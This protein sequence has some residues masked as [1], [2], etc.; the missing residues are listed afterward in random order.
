MADPLGLPLLSETPSPDLPRPDLAVAVSIQG[1][2]PTTVLP[3]RDGQEFHP[4]LGD[5]LL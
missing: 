1:S 4:M 5:G 3:I 2:S